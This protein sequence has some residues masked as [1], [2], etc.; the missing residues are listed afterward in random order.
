MS[1]FELVEGHDLARLEMACKTLDDLAVAEEQIKN[2]G[3]FTKN[4][5]GSTVENPAVKTVKDL[6]LLFVK[7]I[8]E[9]NLDVTVPESR[10]PRGY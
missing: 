8:R 1:E 2:D 6:R 3:M 9:L 5:Y 7:I 10:P 4:R